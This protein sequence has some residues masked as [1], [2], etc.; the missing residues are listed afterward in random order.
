MKLQKT[1]W[2]HRRH[3]EEDA[4]FGDD[5]VEFDVVALGIDFFDALQ[6][7]SQPNHEWLAVSGGD[8]IEKSEGAVVVAATNSQSIPLLIKG[9]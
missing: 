5:G 2:K 9:N 1:G 7:V 4:A 6:F 8:V 3:L